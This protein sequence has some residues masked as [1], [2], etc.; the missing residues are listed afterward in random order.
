MTSAQ[1]KK[2]VVVLV[3]ALAACRVQDES[4]AIAEHILVAEADYVV[5]R[6]EG[7]DG[8]LMGTSLRLIES[9]NLRSPRELRVHPTN[10][11]ARLDGDVQTRGTTA[12]IVEETGAGS[13]GVVWQ[14]T[15]LRRVGVTTV[16]ISA[17]Y[18]TEAS[19]APAFAWAWTVIEGIVPK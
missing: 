12:Y 2:A 13:G 19:K 15:A 8:E 16:E 17:F 7:F 9:G 1:F 10:D 6:P 5:P 18:Q 4:V 11:E 3:L 14:L